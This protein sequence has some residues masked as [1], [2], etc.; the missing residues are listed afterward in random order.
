[1]TK[2]KQPRYELRRRSKNYTGLWEGDHCFAAICTKTARGV[3]DAQ[4]ILRACESYA[5]NNRTAGLEAAK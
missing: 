4:L 3:L 2:E 5:V 1:M